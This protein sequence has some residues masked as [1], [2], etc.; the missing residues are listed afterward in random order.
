M[1][2][3]RYYDLSHSFNW[4]LCIHM[5]ILVAT[6]HRCWGI[7]LTMERK[8]S[9]LSCSTSSPTV[10][11]SW[12]PPVCQL[13]A[14]SFGWVL[15]TH[16]QTVSWPQRMVS[17]SAMAVV[18]LLASVTLCF[19][20]CL[21]HTHVPRLIPLIASNCTS[22]SVSVRRWDYAPVMTS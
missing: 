1:A 12:P 2:L 15:Q 14:S 7:N 17:V 19:L 10:P 11:K 3:N 16:V 8:P 4:V 18:W 5:Y 21:Q 9:F 13:S 6:S 22:K 20:S